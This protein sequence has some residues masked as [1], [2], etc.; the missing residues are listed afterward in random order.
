MRTLTW[1]RS[2]WIWPR[3]GAIGVTNF[4]TAHLRVARAT[5]I[6]LVSNQVSGS[7]L[8]RRFTQRLGPY[9]AEQGV[10]LLCYGTVLGGFLTERWLGAPEPDWQTLE[11]WSQMK[12]KRFI[13]TAM[14]SLEQ[15]T[16]SIGATSGFVEKMSNDLALFNPMNKDAQQWSNIKMAIILFNR[17]RSKRR[18]PVN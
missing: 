7:L 3:I 6:R 12:Y 15:N 17:I 10:G 8:D 4:D 18:L 9:C 13:D 5:G 1:Y 16:V 11:T 14:R 2:I